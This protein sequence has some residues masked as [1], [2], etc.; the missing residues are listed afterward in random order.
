M[1]FVVCPA[2]GTRIKAGRAHCLRCFESLPDPDAMPLPSILVSLGWSRGTMWIGAAAASVAALAL[3]AIIWRTAPEAI[4]DRAR[5][6]PAAVIAAASGRPAPAPGDVADALPEPVR[7][8]NGDEPFL[9]TP[10]SPSDGDVARYRQ[11]LDHFKLAR[12]AAD[13]GKWTHAIEAYGE[14]ARLS[15]SDAAAHYNLALA[16]HRRGDERDAIAAFHKAVALAPDAAAFHL[17]LAAAYENV[18]QLGD[19]SREYRAFV[20]AAPEA[21]EADRVRTR[22]AALSTGDTGRSR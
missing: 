10:S 2:C 9:D 21:P 14:A 1:D 13:A 12:A 5:P 17:P 18:G 15:Q 8:P 3:V 16:F 11:T 22:L 19:A 7:P 4:D 6:A 20:A